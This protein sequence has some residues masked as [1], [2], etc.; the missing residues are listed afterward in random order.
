[1][2]AKA[3]R[4]K[5]REYGVKKPDVW[6]KQQITLTIRESAKFRALVPQIYGLGDLTTILDLRAIEQTKANVEIHGV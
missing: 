4:A 1:M 6:G 3:I 2:N 5:L